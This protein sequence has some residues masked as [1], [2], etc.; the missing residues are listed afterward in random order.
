MVGMV[1]SVFAFSFPYGAMVA[2]LVA[3]APQTIK[4]FVIAAAL[5]C[6]N[7]GVIEVGECLMVASADWM[8]EV[9][10]LPWPACRTI[11]VF[12]TAI[13]LLIQF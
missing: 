9:P 4:A 11:F 12:A 13:T 6:V 2:S 3:A 8:A 1:V 5:F 10:V 7:V